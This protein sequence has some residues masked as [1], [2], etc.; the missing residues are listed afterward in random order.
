MINRIYGKKEYEK[1]N[2]KI[3]LFGGSKKMTTDSFLKFRFI[4]CLTM[5]VFVLFFV[6]YGIVLAPVLTVLSYFLIEY[7]LIDVKLKKREKRLDAQ[8]Y[9]YF[10]VL[11]LGLESGRNLENAIKMACKY[12]DSEISMEFR[13]TLKQVN[14]GKSLTESLKEMSSRIPSIAINNIILNME[15]SSLFGNSIIDT[16]HNQLDFLNNKQIMEVKSEINKIPNKI[17]IV[18]VLIFVPLIML[19]ILGPLICQT[20]KLNDSNNKKSI[21]SKVIKN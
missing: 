3:N 12:I 19:I 11:T 13:H 10:E 2:N 16:M 8:S 6:D 18:S 1:I 5:F 7:L 14:F 21:N 17:S 9:Y 4:F 15:Q 20:D